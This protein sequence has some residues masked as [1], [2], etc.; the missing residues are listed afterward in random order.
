MWLRKKGICYFWM[1]DEGG[2]GP[3]EVGTCLM[4]YLSEKAM[5]GY[6]SIV[7]FSDATGSQNR[8]YILIAA[9]LH[10]IKITGLMEINHIFFE[11][12]HSQNEGDSIHS[13]IERASKK[14]TVTSPDEW[15]GIIKVAQS[16]NPLA[17]KRLTHRDFKSFKELATKFFSNVPKTCDGEKVMISMAKFIT[18]RDGEVSVSNDYHQNKCVQMRLRRGWN[19]YELKGKYREPIGV[20]DKKKKDLMQLCKSFAIPPTAH[21]FFENLRVRST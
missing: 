5:E 12:G 6:S 10:I 14:L 11:S 9:F 17:L 2:K 16:A 7:A 18:I 15:V 4:D 19:E 20:S 8:S 21:S 3:E 1:E 13:S